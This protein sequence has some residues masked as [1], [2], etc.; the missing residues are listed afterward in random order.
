[1]LTPSVDSFKNT[2]TEL[3]EKWNFPNCVESI[4]GKHIRV[5]CPENS[6]SMYFNYKQYYSII[7]MAV[8][9][10]SLDF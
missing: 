8:A 2:V 4:D 10:G 5:R 6:V 1:M 3:Y 9:D 7:L